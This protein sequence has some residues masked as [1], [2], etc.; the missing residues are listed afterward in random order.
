MSGALGFVRFEAVLQLETDL[1]IGNGGVVPRKEDGEAFL[2]ASVVRDACGKPVIPGTALKGVL[3]AAIRAACSEQEAGRLFGS[4][5]E[6]G[7]NTKSSGQIGAV[8]L[9]AARQCKPGSAPDLPTSGKQDTAM[10]THVALGR[11]YGVA[12][13]QKLFHREIVRPAHDFGCRALR[14]MAQM[15]SAISRRLAT[16]SGKP[17]RH[18]G[19]ACRSAEARPRET[20]R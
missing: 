3:R 14:E 4:I 7:N 17:S 13:P 6:S 2:M 10:A 16:I 12:D 19:P 18:S 1:H 15:P 20:G 9:Y 8:T 11:K 5:K